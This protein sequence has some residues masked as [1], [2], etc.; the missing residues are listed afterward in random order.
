MKSRI[1]ALETNPGL[2]ALIR[3]A[4]VTTIYLTFMAASLGLTYPV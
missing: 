4:V 3:A 1:R 2:E